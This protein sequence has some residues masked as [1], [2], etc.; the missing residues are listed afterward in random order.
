[1]RTD[2]ATLD[3][4]FEQFNAIRE[5]GVS[6]TEAL[7][8]AKIPHGTYYNRMRAQKKKAKVRRKASKTALTVHHVQ[9]PAQ[10]Q[11]QA[12]IVF[13]SPADLANFVRNFQ[14]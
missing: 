5:T 14:Q 4:K 12:F 8:Q 9:A 1:M 2:T 3:K 7:K 10:V 6:I 11:A 13:G